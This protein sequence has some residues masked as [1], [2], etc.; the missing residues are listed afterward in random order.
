MSQANAKQI[1]GTHYATTY[2]HW[3]LLPDLGYT[4]EYYV[5][6][7]TKYLTRWRKKAGL[8]DLLKGQHFIEKLLELAE[9]KGDRFLPYGRVKSDHAL[10]TVIRTQM[11]KRLRDYFDSNDTDPVTAAICVLV[12][13]ARTTDMLREAI[14]ECQKLVVEMQLAE[15]TAKEDIRVLESKQFKF[16]GYVDEG[17]GMRWHCDF[18]NTPMELKMSELPAQSHVCQS[19][20][21]TG[22]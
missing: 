8:R 16:L 11:K 12:I 18:C 19:K 15:A 5:G 10:Q 3:D 4:H 13:F 6:A 20:R 14:S 21:S 7:A 2:Q 22:V 17:T 9:I 1:D